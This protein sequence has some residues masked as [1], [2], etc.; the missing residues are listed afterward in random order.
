MAKPV[1]VFLDRHAPEVQAVIRE[2]A[3]DAVELRMVSSGDP[4]ER[5]ALA[6]EAAFF[7]GGIEPI[8]ADLIDA[9]PQLRL[10]HKWGVGVDKI[11]LGAARRRG[12]PVAITAGANAVAVAEFTVLLML[13]ALRQLPRR[14]DQLRAGQWDVA[15][16]EA[17][18]QSLQLRGRTVGIVGM[19]AIGREVAR[20]LRAFEARL[21]YFDVRRLPRADEEALGLVYAELDDLLRAADIVTLHLPLLPST[22]NLLSRERIGR[23]KPNAIVVNTARGGLVD[24][25]ALREALEAGR[26]LGA[27]VDVFGEEPPPPDHPLRATG[28]PGLVATPHLAGSVFDN[29]AN[30]ARHIFD[31][32]LRVL[33]GH[34]LPPQDLVR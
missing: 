6:R 13:A 3:P 9:A 32:V 20:R 19:G 5:Y 16:A 18:R 2:E 24:E 28:A 10:I 34:P 26:I 8:P 11:D 7:V 31:N 22:R 33:N 14:V 25:E 21:T 27:G 17:R 29:V 4:S 30:V 12:I 23:L 15:R 1:V